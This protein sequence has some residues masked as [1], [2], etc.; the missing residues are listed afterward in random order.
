LASLKN[1]YPLVFGKLEFSRRDIVG[2]HLHTVFAF[3]EETVRVGRDD[4][5]IRGKPSARLPKLSKA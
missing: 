3:V 4:Q 2:F 5:P 1:L